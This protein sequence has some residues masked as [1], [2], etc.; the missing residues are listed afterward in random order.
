MICS[1]AGETAVIKASSGTPPPCPLPVDGEGAG[2]GWRGGLGVCASLERGFEV[3]DVALDEG[4]AGVLDGACA[5]ELGEPS[6]GGVGG[7]ASAAAAGHRLTGVVEVLKDGAVLAAV[8]T[9]A[10]LRRV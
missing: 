10:A 1:V 5:H 2:R 7:A 8:G 3:G 6:R 4:V 9:V